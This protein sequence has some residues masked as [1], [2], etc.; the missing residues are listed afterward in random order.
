MQ[1]DKNFHKAS[2]LIVG[3]G[4]AGLAAAITVKKANPALSV[5]VLDKALR[6]GYHNLS[7]AVIET[8]SLDRLLDLAG[9][10]YKSSDSY[11]EIVG[12]RVEKDAL[13]FLT[14]WGSINISPVVRI[15]KA[16]GHP[17][18]QMDHRGDTLVSV[19]KLTKWLSSIAV[20]AGVE[21]MHGFSVSGVEVDA[22]GKVAGLKLKDQGLNREG[23]KKSN[24]LEGEK[25]F[26][27]YYLFAEGAEG[28][29]TEKF[30]AAAGLKRE[31]K[32]LYS[33]GIKEVIKV[34]P[35]AY[36]VF[37]AN[38]AMHTLGYPLWTPLLGPSI[39]G[40]SF[41]YSAGEN[42]IA[43]GAIIG[44][45][46]AEYDFNPQ[47]AFTRFKEHPYVQRFV[48]G[49][50]VNEAGA[51][52]IPEGGYY[53]VPRN[54][55]G[56]IGHKNAV[57][58][59]D[60][61]GFVNMQKI[62]GLHNAIDSGIMAGEAIVGCA[63]RSQIDSFAA[64]YTEKLNASS[65]IKELQSAKNFRQ[66]IARF[67]NLFGMPLST[68]SSVFPDGLAQKL[69]DVEPEHL[70]LKRLSY[71]YKLARPFDKDA[72]V[73]KA[74]VEH[75]ED[76]PAHCQIIDPAVCASQCK[77]KFAQP[78]IIF[79]PAGVYEEV[80]GTVKPVNFTNCLHCKTCQ[81]K[82][83]FAN[84]HWTPLEGGGGPRYREV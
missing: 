29:L 18:G 70:A 53:A 31:R 72:F 49:G 51:K 74:G 26:A 41:M 6:P 83:P 55:E 1:Q 23:Q 40:G 62:K 84:V 67:G 25:I 44:A 52:L 58:V 81:R 46:W 73:A 15:A 37:G 21:V 48:K 57:L 9:P 30:V 27:D 42:L 71:K 82:C 69:F 47:E 16:L 56:H 50:S 59:G 5:C 79:C 10:D 75:N 68:L 60:A 36:E 76:Q 28:Y 19:A 13:M 3:A 12:Q 14:S 11:K 20:A 54:N 24:Y 22:D 4:V 63:S 80:E 77:G 38:T 2:V 32:Q 39:F 34:K 65:V 33:V 43:L 7:G 64:T 61:A 8:E 78:C 45:D 35:E 17:L 66:C